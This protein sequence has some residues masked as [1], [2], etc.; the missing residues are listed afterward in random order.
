MGY[1][2]IGNEGLKDLC[3]LEF[4]ELK[5]LNLNWNNISDIKVFEKV[6]FEKLEILNLENNKISDKNSI[7]KKLKVKQLYI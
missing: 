1:K 7:I 6:Q 2:H 3:K 4:K 5:E